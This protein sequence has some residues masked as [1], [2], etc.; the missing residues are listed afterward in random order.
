MA[1]PN[2][3]DRPVLEGADQVDALEVG[4]TVKAIAPD[5]LG[6]A[7]E[8]VPGDKIEMVDGE[9]VRDAIDFRFNF[10]D[11]QVE[12]TIRRG[13]VLLVYDIEKDPDEDLGV[14]FEDM[15][16]LKCDNK[17]VFCFLHQMPKKLRKT[18]YYQDDDYRLSFLHGAYVTL[19]NLSDDEFDRIVTQRLS[20]M[21]VSVHATDPMVRGGLL[22]RKGPVDVLERLDFLIEA[23]IEIHTQVVFCPGINDGEHLDQTIEDLAA[24]YPAVASLGVVPLGLTKF[25]QNLPELA[26][27]TGPDCRR[28]LKQVH[29]H[30]ERFLSSLGSR[31]VYAGDEF[32]LQSEIAPPDAPRYDG[33]PLVENGIGMVRR[34][35]DDFQEGLDSF[36]SSPA[37]GHISIVTGLLGERFIAP[38][39]S[40]LSGLP[41]LTVDVIPVKNDFL[42]HGITVSGLLA[43]E[44]ILNTLKASSRLGDRILLPPNSANHEG[45]LLDDMTPSQIGTAIGKTVEVGSYSL[46]DSIAGNGS[47]TEEMDPGL[48]HPYITSHQNP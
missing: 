24:R 12:L 33:F 29:A 13:E 45:I 36:S 47:R 18:L 1:I 15:S 27:V 4:L 40:R 5:S 16:I 23:G 19:T 39:A 34:F 46:L 21:Y 25:R 22:G 26:A 38:M 2:H 7:L 32:Y 48:D 8:L 42:G 28:V 44:D 11:E 17:C 20:P 35:L 6:E 31:F 10:G 37:S 9:P 43:G 14:T 41:G 3:S 30:Q